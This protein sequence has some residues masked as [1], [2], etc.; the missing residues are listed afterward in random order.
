MSWQEFS[1]HDFE[2]VPEH[3]V[4]TIVKWDIVWG[5]VHVYCAKT[6]G[7]RWVPEHT[8]M[9]PIGKTALLGRQLLQIAA[10]AHNVEAIEKVIET[11]H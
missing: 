10:E 6:V 8:T 5:W 11:A 9:I 2:N 4:D 7:N 3:R 1:V